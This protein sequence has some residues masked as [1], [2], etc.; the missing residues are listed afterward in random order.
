ML[1]LAVGGRVVGAYNKLEG[2]ITDVGLTTSS[3]NDLTSTLVDDLSDMVMEITQTDIGFT[4]I[5]SMNLM[6]MDH[7]NIGMRYE[8]TTPLELVTKNDNPDAQHFRDG[9]K[10][11]ADM[12]AMLGLGVSYHVAPMMRVEGSFNYFFNKSV[13]WDGVEDDLDNGYEVGIGVE[14]SMGPWLASVGYLYSKTGA[15]T[16]YRNGNQCRRTCSDI[17]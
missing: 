5:I 13:N 14:H 6:H 15:T 2:S 1:S 10:T 12:P 17:Y 11:N 3:G 9:E 8:F 7:M 4:G 16:T